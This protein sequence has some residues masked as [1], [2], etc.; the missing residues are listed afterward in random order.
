MLRL[1]KNE[2]IYNNKSIAYFKSRQLVSMSH[3]KKKSLKND[4]QNKMQ[5]KKKESAISLRSCISGLPW[6]SRG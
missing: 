1:E 3:M 4:L 5:W 6:G 2:I